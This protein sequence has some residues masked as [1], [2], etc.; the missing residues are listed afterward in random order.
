MSPQ[1]SLQDR[2][3]AGLGLGL[4]A[5]SP[6]SRPRVE[7]W[8]RWESRVWPKGIG[9]LTPVPWSAAVRA[10]KGAVG[11]ET[12]PKQLSLTLRPSQRQGPTTSSRGELTPSTLDIPP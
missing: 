3:Y 8:S 2:V 4:L 7:N 9:N 1:K 6:G 5:S 11:E 12:V 10:Q